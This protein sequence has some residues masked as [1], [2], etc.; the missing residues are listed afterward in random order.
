MGIG[1]IGIIGAMD[2]EISRYLK[3]IDQANTTVI[4]GIT[5]Y[6][7]TLCQVPVV[8]CKSGVGKVNAAICTQL[9]VDRF[10]VESVIFTGV[11]GAVHPELEIGDIVISTSCQQHDLDA[12]PLGFARG[13]I[14]FQETSVFPADTQLISWAQEASQWIEGAKVFTGKVLSGDQFISDVGTVRN[15]REEFDGYCVEMEGAAVAHVCYLSGVPYVVIRSMSDRADHSAQVNFI[16]FTELAA[17]RSFLM[18][19]HMLTHLQK[20]KTRS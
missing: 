11:A 16:E 14:P 4:Q 6:E 3:E 13:T 8:I 17:E 12:S 18:V 2:S 10:Q 9:L 19:T 5:Y 20:T 1:K 15:L 7:G